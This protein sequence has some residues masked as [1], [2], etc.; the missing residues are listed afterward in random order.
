MHS[1]HVNSLQGASSI[2]TTESRPQIVALLC[3]ADFQ[4]RPDTGTWSHRDGR[5][6]T[7]QEQDTAFTA[8]RTDME[9]AREQFARYHDYLQTKADAPAAL[10]NFLAPFWE[11]L[12]KKTLGNAVKLMNKAEVA[13]LN[14]RL[15]AVNEPL[16]PF[17]PYTF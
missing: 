16:R 5:P 14:R 1:D 13:E 6:F 4:K 9:E 11:Q 10:D 15:A 12:H 17:T 2:P 3:D 7:Q 8:T